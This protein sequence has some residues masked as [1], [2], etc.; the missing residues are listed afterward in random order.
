MDDLNFMWRGGYTERYH[1][2]PTLLKDTVGHHSYN[3]ACIIMHLRPDCSVALLKAALLHDVA[4][5]R[6][7]DMPAPIKR[8]LPDYIELEKQHDLVAGARAVIV[9]SMSFRQVYGDY[10]I[11]VAAASGVSIDQSLSPEE[12]WVLKLADSMDGMRFCIQERRMG[13]QGIAEVFENF[14]GYVGELMYGEDISLIDQLHTPPAAHAQKQD[15][16][17]AA[18]LLREWHIVN[19]K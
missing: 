12:T 13:N 7:G 8:A 2:W 18:N 9:G 15:L 16:M 17:L 10:E 14:R 1:T 6:T 19:S 4:E 3:V 11:L 5:H